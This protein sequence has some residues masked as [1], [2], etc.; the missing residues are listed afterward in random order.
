[1]DTRANN[2]LD[3]SSDASKQ[4]SASSGQPDALGVP[5]T[6]VEGVNRAKGKKG[7]KAKGKA[8]GATL[9]PNQRPVSQAVVALGSS[10]TGPSTSSGAVS[11]NQDEFFSAGW[12]QVSRKGG[13]SGRGLGSVP[14]TK[15]GIAPR[16]G[17]G[18]A[19]G[20][21]TGK[22]TP[23]AVLAK[24]QKKKKNKAQRRQARLARE[25]QTAGPTPTPGPSASAQGT[26]SSE[27][28]GTVSR[29]DNGS[30]VT[31]KPES[32]PSAGGSKTR[33][34]AGGK[35]KAQRPGKWARAAA[36]RTRLDDTVS[37]RGEHKRQR[38][39]NTRRA[40]VQYSQ[41]VAQKPGIVVT[42]ATTG[43]ITRD[44][45][46]GILSDIN[47]RI[48]KEALDAALG[49]S[50]G[51]R[52]RFEGRPTY[53][54]GCLLLHAADAFTEDWVRRGVPDMALPSNVTLVVKKR[55]EMPRRIQC[56]V[57]VPDEDDFWT[58]ASDIGKVLHY[59]NEWAGVNRWLVST[60]E[61]QARGWFITLSIPEDRLPAIVA[62]GRCLC[63]GAGTAFLKFKGP[64]GKFID[65]PPAPSRE[66]T[67][68]TTEAAPVAP[69]TTRPAEPM[70]LTPS[71]EALLASPGVPDC[72]P[73]GS[74]QSGDELEGELPSEG[75]SLSGQMETGLTLEADEGHHNDGVLFFNP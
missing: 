7:H 53:V 46:K 59:Q 71:E 5:T 30:G 9:T 58:A 75:D 57:F 55:S 38:L 50:V 4:A 33:P 11:T 43:F 56:A 32:A 31:P 35:T 19:S 14:P 22:S 51:G 41:A 6:S 21:A 39:D 24:P 1:M 3:K 12:Q 26:G 61:K 52:P 34:D 29:S 15:T 42:D 20:S 49:V 66:S 70:E 16:I 27:R 23:T 8:A 48:L 65:T 72:G 40:G 2:S 10:S 73:S 47:K 44:T 17:T 74:N 36:K 13:R 45:A 64:G 18:S 54:D 60:A 25:G 69:S 67:A 28:V 63:C 68:P 62:K 37:P